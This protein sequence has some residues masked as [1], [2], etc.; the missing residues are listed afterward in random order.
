MIKKMK[1]FLIGFAA[2]LGCL[3][4]ALLLT[5]AESGAPGASITDYPTALWYMLTTLTTVGYGDTYPVTVLGRVIGGVLQ[6]FS[7]GLLVFLMGLL[8]TALRGRLLPRLRIKRTAGKKA[9]I[10][11]CANEAAEALSEN[12]RKEQPH[13]CLIFA[14]QKMSETGPEHGLSVPFSPSEIIK[15][16]GKRGENVVFCM[17]ENPLENEALSSSL[18]E[19]PCRIYCMTDHESDLLPASVSLFDKDT[20]RARLYWQEYPLQKPD[21]RIVLIGEGKAAEALL[22]QALLNNV[23]APD[24]AVRYDIFGKFGHFRRNHPVLNQGFP[25]TIADDSHDELYF[26][27]EP[28]NQDPSILMDAD[29]I[30]LCFREERDTADYTAAL[31]KYFP[32]KGA[33]HA[34]LS[35]S[36]KDVVSF[37]NNKEIFTPELVMRT[38]L[39]RIAREMNEIYQK[40]TGAGVSWEELPGFLRRSNMASADHLGAKIRFILGE[41]ADRA[42]LK[43]QCAEAYEKFENASPELRENCRRIEHTRWLRFHLMNNWSY[44]PVRDNQKRQHPLMLPFDDLTPEDQAKDDYAWELL[45]ALSQ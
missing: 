33:V 3:L 40:S 45:R 12:L 15:L 44:A 17:G 5:L 26:H 11:S 31:L 2:V 30:I 43:E 19:L 4:L 37:G 9:Y 10:F 14:E 27:E 16:R 20:C 34:C 32:M 29:R 24:N 6:L 23:I 22:L 8:F 1:P 28:W 38:G 21:E 7:L 42:R 36:H 39:D 25:A 35:I 41:P 13:A 18:L